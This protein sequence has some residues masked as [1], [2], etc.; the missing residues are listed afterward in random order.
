M[1]LRDVNSIK[2][3]HEEHF[4]TMAIVTEMAYGYLASIIGGGLALKLTLLG[5]YR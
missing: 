4:A 2:L 1:I 3:T 5:I